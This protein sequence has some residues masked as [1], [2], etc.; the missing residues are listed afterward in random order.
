MADGA[1]GY[2][3]EHARKMEASESV[4]PITKAIIL[5]I[6][7]GFA[8][9]TIWPELE[10][11][12]TIADIWRVKR[13]RLACAEDNVTSQDPVGPVFRGWLALAGRCRRRRAFRATL[14]L[15][16]VIAGAALRA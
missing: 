15:E 11:Q 3:V 5:G 7:A 13:S 8:C 1:V 4:L 16:A 6:H 2:A 12:E 14:T 10:G 9:V